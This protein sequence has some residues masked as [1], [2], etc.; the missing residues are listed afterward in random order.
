M[1]SIARLAITFGLVSISVIVHSSVEEQGVTL[2]QVHAADSGRIRL[3][4]TCEVCGQEVP[5]QQIA[6]GYT[7]A[8]GRTVVLTEDDLAQLPLPSIKQIDVVGFIDAATVDPLRLGKGYWLSPDPATAKPY[9]L[10]RDA[11]REAGQA[12]V[13]KITLRSGNHEHLALLRAREDMLAIQVLRWPDEVRPAEG[14]APPADVT[15]RPQEVQM[16]VA[17]MDAISQDFDLAALRDRYRDAMTK[18]VTAKLEGEPV[19]EGAAVTP[20][21]EDVVDLM[22]ALQAS[23]DAHQHD[24]STGENE[25]PER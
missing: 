21:P 19:P 8:R 3:R 25:H 2:H 4:R 22:A 20:A 14:V 15:V 1:P 6:R 13:T 18:L 17:L 12:A 7:D 23:I 16:A 9:I 5:Y 11:M 10:L 24:H